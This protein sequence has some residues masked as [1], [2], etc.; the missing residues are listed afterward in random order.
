ML[1]SDV[2]KLG[3][4]ISLVLLSFVAIDTYLLALN[5]FLNSLI[6]FS[7]FL[8]QV[9]EIEIYKSEKLLPT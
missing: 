1:S 8:F 4:N 9:A 2:S 7:S 6:C 3:T 5:S